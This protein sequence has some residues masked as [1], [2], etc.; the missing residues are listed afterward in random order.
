MT[1]TICTTVAAALLGVATLAAA[2]PAIA[3]DP[4]QGRI[5][6][7][8]AQNRAQYFKCAEFSLRVFQAC[9]QQAGGDSTK[10]R[11]CRAH[12]HGNLARCRQL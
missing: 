4:T 12:Y 8:Q 5:E 10:V 7:R 9:S 1:I 11:Q 6:Q 2:A 3:K